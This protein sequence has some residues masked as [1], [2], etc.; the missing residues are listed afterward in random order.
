VKSYGAVGDGVAGTLDLSF[1]SHPNNISLFQTTRSLS[2]KL[3][4]VRLP[5]GANICIQSTIDGGSCGE[6]CA[7]ST[8]KPM[9]IYFPRGTVCPYEPRWNTLFPL[10]PFTPIHRST[11]LRRLSFREY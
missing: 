3:S 8:I 11:V 6:G 5:A 2:T 1:S 4:A 7:S 9:L 10:T